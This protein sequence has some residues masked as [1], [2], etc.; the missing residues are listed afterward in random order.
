MSHAGLN[1][2]IEA[3]IWEWLDLDMKARIK[4]GRLAKDMETK[5]LELLAK[6]KI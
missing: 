5:R 1:K 3:S 2:A 6:G 4:A